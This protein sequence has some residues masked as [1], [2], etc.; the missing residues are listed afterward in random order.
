MSVK[1]EVF[2]PGYFFVCDTILS[3]YMHVMQSVQ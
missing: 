2:G 3:F 1:E